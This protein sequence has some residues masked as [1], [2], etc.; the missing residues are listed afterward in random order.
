MIL[1]V[2]WSSQPAEGKGKI[3]SGAHG[4]YFCELPTNH[5]LMVI[6]ICFQIGLSPS[7]LHRRYA[8]ISVSSQPSLFAVLSMLLACSWHS[9]HGRRNEKAFECISTYLLNIL[10]WLHWHLISLLL[11]TPLT[12]VFARSSSPSL[13]LCVLQDLVPLHGF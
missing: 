7:P 5:F 11:L 12:N 4:L 13:Q 8:V 1:V 10:L 9:V 3:I 2:K 6:H